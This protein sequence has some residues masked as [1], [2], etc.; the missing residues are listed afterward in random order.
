MENIRVFYIDVFD[1]NAVEKT[2][3]LVIPAVNEAIE[4]GYEIT[5]Y[6]AAYGNRA[7][8]ALAGAIDRGVFEIVSLFVAPDFRRKGVATALIQRLREELLSYDMM[9]RADYTLENSEEESL[10]PFLRRSGFVLEKTGKP[11]FYI[12][13]IGDMEIKE[14][15]YNKKPSDHIVAFRESPE[16]ALK[17]ATVLSSKEAWPLPEGGLLSDSV[18]KDLSFCTIFNGNIMAYIAVNKEKGGIVEIPALWSRLTDSRLLMEMLKKSA[19]EVQNKYP[20]DTRAAMMA[21][22]SISEKIIIHIFPKATPCS[23]SFISMW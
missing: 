18:D 23:Y 21:I 12:S 5:L 14:K 6:L 16:A 15:K 17:N 11:C 19:I 1:K 10:G 9:V 22:S 2:E 20:S 13:K 8:G 7:A 3:G 4:K